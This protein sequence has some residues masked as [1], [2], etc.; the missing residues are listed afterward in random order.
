MVASHR[1]RA[2]LK[3]RAERGV[4]PKCAHGK[5][6]GRSGS[7][8]GRAGG[9]EVFDKRLVS[10]AGHLTEENAVRVVLLLQP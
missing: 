4:Q 2:W 7:S 1:F 10:R 9:V 6:Q 3:V 5:G 8:L